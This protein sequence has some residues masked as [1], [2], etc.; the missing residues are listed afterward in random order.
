MQDQNGIKATL[1]HV[2]LQEPVSAVQNLEADGIAMISQIELPAE[3]WPELF[4]WLSQCCTSADPRH[5]AV[6][7]RVLKA[8]FERVG[9]CCSSESLCMASCLFCKARMRD[10]ICLLK[11]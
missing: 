10:P 7:L 1:Q 2:I 8:L 11:S 3:S 9:E 6:G 4:P 5:K